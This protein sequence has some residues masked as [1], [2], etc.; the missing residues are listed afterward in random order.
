MQTAFGIA[1]VGP[2]L[3]LCSLGQK[4]SRAMA[5]MLRWPG[6]SHIEMAHTWGRVTQPL[7]WQ[8]RGRE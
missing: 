4:T 1:L 6:V 2:P 8:G 3:K 5:H 7:Y